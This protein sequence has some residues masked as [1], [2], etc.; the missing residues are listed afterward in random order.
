HAYAEGSLQVGSVK[1]EFHSADLVDARGVGARYDSRSNYYGL[2]LGAGYVWNFSEKSGLEAYGKYLHARRDSDR[3]T[4][5]TGDPLRFNAV[6]SHRLRFGGRYFWTTNTVKPYIGIAW[7][8]E[9]DGKAK[10]TSYNLPIKAPELKGD[11][12]IVELGLT[13]TPSNTLPLTVN[14]GLQGYTGK[15]EGVSGNL[16]VEYRF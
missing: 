4:L 13:M 7:E 6:E 5:N 15:R 12:G 1:T 3:V 10:A 14:F 11:T 8:H 16:R 9:F 2:H